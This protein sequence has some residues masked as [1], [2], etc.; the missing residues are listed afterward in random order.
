MRTVSG[1]DWFSS[2]VKAVPL[3]APKSGIM[4]QVPRGLGPRGAIDSM[5]TAIVSP[6]SAPSIMIGPF[7][8]FTKGM[9]STFEGRS[10][11]VLTLPSKASRVST[12]MR[13]PGFTVI[14]GSV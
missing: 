4:Q 1:S 3:S 2:A 10:C 13:S 6:G 5:Y 9:V 12:T 8:G 14:T 7:C 11:S